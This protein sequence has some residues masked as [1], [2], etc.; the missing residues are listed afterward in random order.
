MT[1]LQAGDEVFGIDEGAFAEYARARADKLA[2]K[3]KN[4]TVEQAA[5]TTISALQGVRDRG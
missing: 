3:P 2:P 4:L 5:A 1:T